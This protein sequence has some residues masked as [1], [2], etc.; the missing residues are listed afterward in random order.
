MPGTSG[1]ILDCSYAFR[2]GRSPHKALDAFW[3]EA[4]GMGGGWAL[5]LDIQSY[6]DT[7][8]KHHLRNFLDQRVRDGV[9]RRVIDKWLKAGVLEE[10]CVKH[11]ETGVPQGG[12]I[13]PILSNIYFAPRA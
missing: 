13:S 4:K 11:P 6:Y 7:V 1:P 3:R 5:E 10:G 12:V 2:T 8:G 9:L